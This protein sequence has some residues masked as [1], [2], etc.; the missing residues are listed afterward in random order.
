MEHS[1]ELGNLN[2][3]V[4]ETVFFHNFEAAFRGCAELEE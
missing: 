2:L 4:F 1:A 3:V